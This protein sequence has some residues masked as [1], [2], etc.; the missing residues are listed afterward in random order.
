M[1]RPVALFILDGWG[2]TEPGDGNA[3]S[4]A[5]TP[6]F[7]RL[8]ETGITT[9]LSASGKD[10]GLPDGQMGN[11][12]VGHLNIG[13]G[14]IVFQS[15]VRIS[16]AV[17]DGSLKTNPA[18]KKAVAHALAGNGRLHLMGLLSD[19]GVHSHTAHLN[20]LLELAKEAGLEDVFVHAFLDGRD[21]PP[22]S[23]KGFIEKAEADMAAIGCGSIASVSGRFYAMDRDKRWDR[24]E[25][26]YRLLTDG[27][28]PSGSSALA[29][30]D[31]AYG[32]ALTDEFV[33]PTK[34]AG[35]EGEIG[36]GDAI[37]F[38]NFRPD[39]A[40]Q[41]TRAMVDRDFDGFPR[42][43]FDSC[44]VCMTEYDST[45]EGVAIAF[46]PVG[47]EDTLGEWVAKSGKNQLRIAETEKYAHVTFFF[48]G[49]VEAPNENEERVLIPSPKVATYD[50]K[51]SM[52]A[53]EVT[54]AL[55]AELD[56][57]RHDLVILNFA[58]PDMVGHTG[59]IPAAIEAVET[60]DTCLGRA[61]DAVL[62][63]GGCVF[64]TA[65]HGNAEDMIDVTTGNPKTAHTT[66][67]VPGI[68]VGATGSPRLRDGGR[69]ADIAPTLL[70]LMGI[71]APETMTG[72]S[73]IHP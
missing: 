65:D 67:P 26:A 55:C 53:V 34:I 56:K 8:A 13:A 6:N 15:L 48:N 44:F 10:V 45:I 12:E 27:D 32:E 47:I 72:E 61:V 73:L 31:A 21:T 62:A 3:V 49:G 35:V 54:D 69:L 30:V 58:N 4:L 57:D 71:A 64:I 43:R 42:T 16:N 39:R 14:R 20:G 70:D 5:R 1:T 40:R 24:T 41:L 23:A 19:G 38:F 36:E 7:D 2:C 51:P 60:V 37:I 22:Q 52:S 17:E 11:S 68:L 46:P 59:I 66:N 50:L 28:G 29:V 33:L 25:K 63:K 9:R 18:L